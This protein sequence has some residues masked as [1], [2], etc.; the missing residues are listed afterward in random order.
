MTEAKP[1]ESAP[2]AV[3][4]PALPV[5]AL[6]SASGGQQT[7][8]SAEALEE[9]LVSRLTPIIEKAVQST[10]DRRFSKLDELIS[11]AEKIKTVGSDNIKAAREVVSDEQPV[12]DLGRSEDA[13]VVRMQAESEILLKDAGVPFDDAEY[14]QLVDKYGGRIKRAE[15]WS[16]IV[17][18][19]AEA[20]KRRAAPPNEAQVTPESRSVSPAGSDDEAAAIISKLESMPMP[21]GKADLAERT[22]LK[23]R[24]NELTG[25]TKIVTA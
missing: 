13:A 4:T 7:S 5:P 11:L 22:K 14:K 24:L 9:R 10:K 18:T 21:R 8:E 19:F 3:E 23:N 15:D 2:G 1:P 6:S 20:R 12:Q 25:G 17:R 16:P